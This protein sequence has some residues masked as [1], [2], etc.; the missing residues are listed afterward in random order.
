VHPPLRSLLELVTW[1]A[2]S[3]VGFLIVFLLGFSYSD[4][5]PPPIDCLRWA[6]N[7]TL[8]LRCGALTATAG[9]INGWTS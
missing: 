6:T 9:I 7:Q 5:M 1:L 2:L 8:S 3:S 4:L